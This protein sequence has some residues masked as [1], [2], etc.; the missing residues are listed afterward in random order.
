MLQR[1]ADWAVL[2]WLFFN[3]VYCSVTMMIVDALDDV[4]DLLGGMAES[5]ASDTGTQTEVADT[6]RVVLELICKGVVTLG[7]G[8]DEDADAL[9]GCEIGDVVAHTNN[10]RVETKG[11]LAAVGREVVGD[12]VLNNLQ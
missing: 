7:H 1:A 2:L 11:D 8:S 4:P 9:L 5:T 10:G 6:D 3:D 12:R